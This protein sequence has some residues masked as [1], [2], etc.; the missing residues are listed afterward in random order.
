MPLVLVALGSVC[1][2][3]AATPA[4]RAAGLDAATRPAALLGTF[5][6][7]AVVYLAVP[8]RGTALWHAAVLACL[9]PLHVALAA[10]AGVGLAHGLALAALAGAWWGAGRAAGGSISGA[11]WAALVACGAPAVGY[12]AGDLLGFGSSAVP[13]LLAS[14]WTGPG[15]LAAR[16]PATELADGVPALVAA[17]VV[18]A[19]SLVLER[20]GGAEDRA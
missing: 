7:L 14:P 17:A 8:R 15:L 16:G 3:L 2:G 1:V 11:G 4:G 18:L 6:T 9:A 5:D 10:A 20:R 12:V 13:W 19:G